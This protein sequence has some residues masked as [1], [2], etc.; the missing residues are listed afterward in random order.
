MNV[1][2]LITID[3]FSRKHADAKGPLLAWYREATHASWLSPAD[4]KLRYP[5]VS[6]LSN[7]MVI[8]NIK[9]NRYRLVV[10]VAYNTK[11]VLIRWIGTHSEY[12]RMTF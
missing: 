4:I 1:I 9:G 8:F 12:D 10:Q 6:F 5:S 2:S 7:N 11:I 3:L